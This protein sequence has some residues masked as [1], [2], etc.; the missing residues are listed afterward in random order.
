MID[1][2]RHQAQLRALQDPD[3]PRKRPPARACSG[4]RRKTR[5]ASGTCHRCQAVEER[6][7]VERLTVDE[8]HQII[9]AARAELA[10]RGA[11]IAQA[12]STP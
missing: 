12:L 4:C 11:L 6:R 2:A 9:A 7:V 1:P 5:D 10:R 3:A 8:L